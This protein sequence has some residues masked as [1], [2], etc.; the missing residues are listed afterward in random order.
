MI[1][2]CTH[3]VAKVYNDWNDALPTSTAVLWYG[4]WPELKWLS[5]SVLIGLILLTMHAIMPT[6]LVEAND[7]FC[8][9][10]LRSNMVVF[11][12]V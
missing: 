11:L 4:T 12:V 3:K 10:T 6:E 1:V 5:P 8:S 7:I 2:Q 9:P